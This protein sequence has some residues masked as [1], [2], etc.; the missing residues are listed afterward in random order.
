MV[1]CALTRQVVTYTI[2]F[3]ITIRYF[4][5][6]TP[7]FYTIQIQQENNT[8]KRK[9]LHFKTLPFPPKIQTQIYNSKTHIKSRQHSTS[10]Y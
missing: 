10:T 9:L 1:H 7:E 5:K 2:M 3:S 6:Y 8:F 4:L